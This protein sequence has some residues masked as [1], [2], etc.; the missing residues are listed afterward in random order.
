MDALFGIK[1][2]IDYFFYMFFVTSLSTCAHHSGMLITSPLICALGATLCYTAARKA[3][4]KRLVKYLPILIT[5]ACF[6]FTKYTGDKIITV[7]MIVYLAVV[8]YKN[9]T[10]VEYDGATS[11]FYFCLKL[12]PVPLLLAAIASNKSG[13]VEVMLPYMFMYLVVNVMFMRMLRHNVRIYTDKKFISMNVLEIAGLCGLG[14]L[15]SSGMI[16]TAMKWVIHMIAMYILRPILYGI[17]YIFAGIAWLL[18]KIFGNINFDLS[19]IDL[20]QLSDQLEMGEQE[21]SIM[22]IYEEESGT[23]KAAEITTYVLIAIGA[24]IVVLLIILLFRALTRM[25]KR[26]DDNEFIGEREAIADEDEEKKKRLGFNPR[27]RVRHYYRK[28]LKLVY[29]IG[30]DENANYCTIDF[31]NQVHHV[32]H[33]PSMHSLRDVYIKARYSSQDIT[34]DDVR[35]AKNAYDGLKKKDMFTSG[36]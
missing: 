20:S 28:F 17:L 15:F 27:D 5:A 23:G 24:I 29:R 22:E 6:V 36:E 4:K 25:G 32:L 13:F 1:M 31:V 16:V 12:I 14:W 33:R 2:L 34:S 3:P 26:H 19:E 7:P 11:R 9:I 8:M 10:Y 35:Q 18:D 21:K 30:V